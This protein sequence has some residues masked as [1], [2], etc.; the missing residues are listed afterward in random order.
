M[1]AL[2]KPLGTERDLMKLDEIRRLARGSAIIPVDR[3]DK[4]ERYTFCIVDT[5]PDRMVM[6]SLKIAGEVMVERLGWKKG[7]ELTVKESLDD[8]RFSIATI[9]TNKRIWNCNISHDEDG[10]VITIPNYNTVKHMLGYRVEIGAK[11]FENP[12]VGLA[13]Q[14]IKNVLTENCSWPSTTSIGID[15]DVLKAIWILQ[16]QDGRRNILSV[17]CSDRM[18]DSNSMFIFDIPHYNSVL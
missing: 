18:V 17:P 10:S 7:S 5:M 12:I 4:L 16:I 13:M 6:K 2:H 9:C 1:I 11:S 14:A 8:N 15:K 3:C